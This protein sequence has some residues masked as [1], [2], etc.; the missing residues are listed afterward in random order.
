MPGA[1]AGLTRVLPG[2]VSGR[3][4]AGCGTGRLL[5]RERDRAYSG[6]CGRER[7][8]NAEDVLVCC[9]DSEG[10]G[11]AGMRSGTA[12]RAT[13]RFAGR[14][15]SAEARVRTCLSM[16]SGERALCAWSRSRCGFG[17]A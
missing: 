16:L 8:E 3:K 4:E 5:V 10:R 13:L 7:K 14:R 6:V 17:C 1:R 9:E 2:S 15:T 11:S 12:R